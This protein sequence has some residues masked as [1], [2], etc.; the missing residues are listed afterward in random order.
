MKL[1]RKFGQLGFDLAERDVIMKRSG[2]NRL[3]NWGNM[4]SF[5]GKLHFLFR[6]GQF[7]RFE[8]PIDEPRIITRETVRETKLTA[9]GGGRSQ[10]RRRRRTAGDRGRCDSKISFSF[11]IL[12]SIYAIPKT[13]PNELVRH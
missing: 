10:Q 12:C 3:R 13:C 2:G 1:D 8:P 11:L 6:F 7:G 9:V 5:G 4:G